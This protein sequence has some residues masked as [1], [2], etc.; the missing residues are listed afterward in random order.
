[1]IVAM[2]ELGRRRPG[3]APRL[4]MDLTRIQGSDRN[5]EVLSV[6]TSL[7]PREFNLCYI[8]ANERYL[9]KG[10][11]FASRKAKEG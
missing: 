1:M 4:E 3:V 5:D 7:S 11:L 2:F 9:I 6:N 8:W 10:D